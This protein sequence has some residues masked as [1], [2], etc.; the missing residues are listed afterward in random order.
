MNNT[1]SPS[2]ISINLVIMK[3][4]HAMRTFHHLTYLNAVH[5]IDAKWGV[6]FG[7]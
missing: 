4:D 7:I 2:H 3:L 1:R 5:L 6:G